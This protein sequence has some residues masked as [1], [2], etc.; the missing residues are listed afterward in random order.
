MPKLPR[1]L[2]GKELASL[3]NKYGYIITRQTGSHIRL[4]NNT[5]NTEHHITI[6]DHRPI[7]IGTLSRI[8][9]DIADYLTIDKET[10]TNELL[11]DR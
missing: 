11:E 3:L 7:K 1:D 10:L 8:L 9:K 5:K 4:T 2:S 6:P